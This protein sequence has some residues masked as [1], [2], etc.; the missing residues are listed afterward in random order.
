MITHCFG[1]PGSG[2]DFITNALVKRGEYERIN[3]PSF[4]GK[5]IFAIIYLIFHPV[6]FSLFC[7]LIIKE[8]W[9]H[10]DLLW[11]KFYALFLRYAAMEEKAII[12]Q[13]IW[14]SKDFIIS[15]G[16]FM[17]VLS[18]FERRVNEKEI[19]KIF[20]LIPG[21]RK[22][23]LITASKKIRYQRIKNRKR[24]PRSY[25]GKK[26]LKQWLPILEENAVIMGDFLYIYYQT[27]TIKNN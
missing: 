10:K 9:H 15:E 23:L 26:Y 19:K 21:C 8:N 4:G 27:N 13:L 5:L 25:K 14:P 22:I 12:K 16:L 2:K 6:S 17:F 11:R 20:S 24:Q 3:N 18:L 7:H 1:L